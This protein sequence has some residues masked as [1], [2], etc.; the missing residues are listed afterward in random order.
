MLGGLRSHVLGFVIGVVAVVLVGV[1]MLERDRNWLLAGMFGLLAG[2]VLSL[3]AEGLSLYNLLAGA[4]AFVVWDT[5]EYA[6]GLD[7][8]VG[9]GG[10]TF[11]QELRNAGSSLVVAGVAGSIA[12][13]VFSAAPGWSSPASLIPLSVGTILLLLGI[14]A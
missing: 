12:W 11:R 7:E 9:G 6:I 14:R 8:H 13:I 2:V 5:G 3:L 1:G 4:L 10:G